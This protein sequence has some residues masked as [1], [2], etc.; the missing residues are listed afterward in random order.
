MPDIGTRIRSLRKESR[1]TLAELAAR[2][3]VSVSLI[4][5]A[6]RNQLSPS[7][8]TIQA[9]SSALGITLSRFFEE[10]TPAETIFR[11]AGLE[12]AP[13]RVLV[14]EA[15]GAAFTSFVT[16][17]P[18]GRSSAIRAEGP[19]GAAELVY[20]AAGSVRIKWG[21]EARELSAGDA[22]YFR[23]GAQRSA[24]NTGRSQAVLFWVRGGGK[25]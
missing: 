21:K 15:A 3:G 19:A 17:V 9:V 13:W 22:A 5:Q 8:A 6:E 2:A 14:S 12:E 1:M 18:P 7:V 20:V 10:E 24:E 25:K 16:R 4:S 23:S 11:G